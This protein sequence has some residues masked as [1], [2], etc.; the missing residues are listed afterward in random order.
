M[1]GIPLNPLTSDMSLP[2]QAKNA[3]SF[4]GLQKPDKSEGMALHK[5]SDVGNL[6]GKT[7]DSDALREAAKAFEAVFMSQLMKQ[8]R[9]TIHKE[10]MFHGGAGE[11][12]F[13][14]MLDEKFAEKMSVRGTGIADM[15]YRQLSRQ[16]GI[17]ESDENGLPGTNGPG[18]ALQQKMQQ[19]Q[20]QI[21]KKEPQP[22][23]MNI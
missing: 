20:K 2:I 4:M 3:Q 8:M 19:L 14:E 18:N 16:Y 1:N 13:T 11:D 10:E 6:M 7:D 17:G 15:L 23:S 5:K 12:I 22:M 21:D 9:S